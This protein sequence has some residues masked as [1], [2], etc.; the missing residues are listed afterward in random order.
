MACLADNPST[1]ILTGTNHSFLLWVVL[2]CSSNTER[3]VG[4]APFC[5]PAE[6]AAQSIRITNNFFIS[7]FV[8][9]YE[10][11]GNYW[12]GKACHQMFWQNMAAPS[13]YQRVASPEIVSDVNEIR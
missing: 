2:S 11:R 8:L 1:A 6:T 13:S 4:A 3:M 12:G 10:T 7:G 5:A 9:R